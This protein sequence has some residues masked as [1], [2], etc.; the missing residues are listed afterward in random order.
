VTA[1]LSHLSILSHGMTVGDGSGMESTPVQAMAD[2][3][4]DPVGVQ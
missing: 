1:G 3:Q 2:G 4:A